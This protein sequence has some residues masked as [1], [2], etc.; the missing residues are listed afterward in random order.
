MS[1]TITTAPHACGANDSVRLTRRGRIVVVLAVM[2]VLV[3]GGFLLGHATS[4]ASA[5]PQKVTV[6]AGETLWTVAERVAP[7]DDPRLVVAR[8]QAMNHLST[9]SVEAG[10]QLLVP[11][12]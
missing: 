8:I 11:A 5:P 1:S 3:I 7:Q 4:Q 12:S 9:P 2:A 10:Q 6:E